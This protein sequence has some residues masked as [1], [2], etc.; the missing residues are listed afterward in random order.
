MMGEDDLSSWKFGV[1][2][3]S[4]G[5]WHVRGVDRVGRTVEASGSDPD[6]LLAKLKSYAQ[7]IADDQPKDARRRKP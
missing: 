2:E 4:A 6:A 3:V 1:E 5:A 7:E